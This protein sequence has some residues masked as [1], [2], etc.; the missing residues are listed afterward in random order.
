M[1]RNQTW[2]FILALAVALSSLAFFTPQAHA[3]TRTDVIT[4]INVSADR[5]HVDPDFLGR[6]LWCESRWQAG[7]T[8]PDGSAGI[9]QYQGIT[10]GWASAAA[11][12]PGASPYD[13]EAAIDTMAWLV[14]RGQSLHWSACL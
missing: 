8:G 10:W 14:A 13:A 1:N 5:H 7:V 12:W 3:Q 6:V 9:A 4:M 11:G 2:G